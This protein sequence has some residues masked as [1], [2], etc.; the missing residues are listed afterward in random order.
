MVASGFAI[1]SL[2]M[3]GGQIE[4]RTGTRL[5]AMLKGIRQWLP[6]T[7]TL[8]VVACTASMGLP[9]F[10]SFLAE[11]LVISAGISA[12]YY[13]AVSILV[14]VIT[15]AY[16]LWMLKRTVLTGADDQRLLPDISRSDAI[17]FCIYIIPLV[18]FTVFSFIVLSP[19]APVA[20]WL[21]QLVQGGH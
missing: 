5:I 21:V 19:A 2:F 16:F 1:G 18:V 12:N 6:L 7:S 9:T 13:T 4:T 11:V 17:A 3:I 10:L 15:G 8:L 14:P 20:Q